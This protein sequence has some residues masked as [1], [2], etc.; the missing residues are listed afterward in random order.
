MK[1]ALINAS[2][3]TTDSTSK[4]LLQSLKTYFPN[5]KI[6]ELHW[7][8]GDFHQQKRKG[9]LEVEM[10]ERIASCEAVVFAFP[11]YIDSVPSHLLRFLPDFE[12]YLK[13]RG[14]YTLKRVY[15]IVN[16]G[17]FDPKQDIPAIE[18]MENWALHCGLT[19]GQGI[20]VCGGGLISVLGMLP[21]GWGPKKNIE[22]SMKQLAKNITTKKIYPIGLVM[23]NFPKF[24]Y[25]IVA[26]AIWRYFILK[27]GLKCRDIYRQIQVL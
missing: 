9:N 24:L 21:K 3:K 23:P 4:V 12:K 6:V 27:N 5:E 16:N 2:P 20:G 17:F 1:I 25:K 13:T 26:E 14:T 7:S 19:F 11:L 22:K 10:F 18:V 15:A 8:S